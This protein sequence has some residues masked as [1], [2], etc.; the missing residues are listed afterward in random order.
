MAIEFMARDGDRR[1]IAQALGL[2]AGEETVSEEEAISYFV[3]GR[4]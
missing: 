3:I 1:R 2:V 4:T